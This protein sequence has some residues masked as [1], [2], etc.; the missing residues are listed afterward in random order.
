VQVISQ[1]PSRIQDITTQEK[2]SGLD[3][4]S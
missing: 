4:S 2:P 3:M 1:P